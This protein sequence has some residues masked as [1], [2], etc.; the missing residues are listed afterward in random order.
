MHLSAQIEMSTNQVL[1]R[2]IFG[3]SS[4]SE[5]KVHSEGLSEDSS[6]ESAAS[7]DSFAGYHQ[8]TTKFLFSIQTRTSFLLATLHHLKVFMRTTVNLIRQLMMWWGPCQRDERTGLP[9]DAQEVGKL[10]GREVEGVVVYDGVSGPSKTQKR[11]EKVLPSNTK[12]DWT[13]RTPSQIKNNIPAYEGP[14]IGGPSSE[15]LGNMKP[16]SRPIPNKVMQSEVKNKKQLKEKQ[17]TVLVANKADITTV[18]SVYDQK[19]VYF[20]TTAHRNIK[21]Q[22]KV[23]RFWA[24][25]AKHFT[26]VSI[27][28]LNL[29][30][31]Y[32]KH[33]HQ[34]DI[35]DQ[36]RLHYRA[37]HKWLR[38]KKWWW[39]IFIWALGVVGVNAYLIYCK[40]C[41]KHWVTANRLEFLEILS[42]Q[43]AHPSP[44]KSAT[45]EKKPPKKR[46]ATRLTPK[47]L[48]RLPR[49]E[50]SHRIGTVENRLHCQWCRLETKTLKKANLRCLTCGVVLC[51][52][53]CWNS[54]HDR[55][56]VWCVFMCFTECDCLV[57]SGR[58]VKTMFSERCILHLSQKP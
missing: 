52:A 20:L 54:F 58:Q 31:D 42:D 15:I 6:S 23:K 50:K 3:D 39:S 44:A 27:P 47:A 13:L 56:W 8:M 7:D 17:G 33:M 35:A 11:P 2:Q 26:T 55:K 34:V 29:L 4:S 9:G 38:L 5:H 21:T 53:A 40:V 36:M 25:V 14:G 22:P 24:P 18:L 57:V 10:D 12:H 46:T 19:P 49:Q 32:N 1:L 51:G 16:K 28:R 41:E 48:S 43:L 45:T 37:D 30:D